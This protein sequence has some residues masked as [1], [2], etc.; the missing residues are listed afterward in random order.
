MLTQKP[1]EATPATTPAAAAAPVDP[2]THDLL[3]RGPVRAVARGEGQHHDPR[4]HVRHR[5]VRGHP[6][7]LERGAGPALRAQGS[8]ARG[9]DPQLLPGHAD[10]RCPL[11]R[12]ADVADPRGRAPQRVP[13]RTPTSGPRSTRARRRS[14][15]SSTA[16]RTSSTSC[17]CRSATTSTWTRGF[18]SAPSRGGA[19]RTT[20]SRRAA[21]SSART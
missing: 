19:S 18:A 5:G 4:L 8:R 14:G 6:R 9:A 17:R 20:R 16:S 3:L 13:R 11:G 10:E 2:E 21:R 12:R 15:S 7:L 1:A